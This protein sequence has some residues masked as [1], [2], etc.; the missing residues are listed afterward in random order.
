MGT[1]GREID[2]P[3]SDLLQWVWWWVVGGGMEIIRYITYDDRFVK[4]MAT[5]EKEERS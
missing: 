1:C 5:E 4:K 3:V 2:V